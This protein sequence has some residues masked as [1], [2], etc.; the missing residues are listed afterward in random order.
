MRAVI[1][2]SAL[3]MCATASHAQQSPSLHGVLSVP[4]GRYVFGQVSEFAKHQYMLDTQTGRLWKMICV[5]ADKS[6]ASSECIYNRL[7]PVYYGDIDV[8]LP[9]VPSGAGRAPTK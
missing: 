2:C 3:V 7:D 5:V 6:A 9:V 8:T 4:G 1:L